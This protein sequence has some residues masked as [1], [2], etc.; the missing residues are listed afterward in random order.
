MFAGFNLEIDKHFFESQQKSFHEYQKS[1]KNIS[2]HNV[3]G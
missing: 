2:E 3:T 1:G